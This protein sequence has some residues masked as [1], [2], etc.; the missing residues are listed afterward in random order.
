MMKEQCVRNKAVPYLPT[1]RLFDGKESGQ[2]VPNI[3]SQ[4]DIREGAKVL[5]SNCLVTVL[6]VLCSV[7]YHE[8]YW[9]SPF[10]ARNLI[11]KILT[12]RFQYIGRFIV[13]LLFSEVT[14]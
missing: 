2:S 11:L 1:C 5:A 3:P 6:V 7:E 9:N 10:S 4:E 13:L 8:L 12:I 14:S